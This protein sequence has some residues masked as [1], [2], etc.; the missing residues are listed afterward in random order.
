M[1]LLVSTIR[2]ASNSTIRF[3]CNNQAFLRPN[4]CPVF[5]ENTILT[6]HDYNN[7]ENLGN[8]ER[9]DQSQKDISYTLPPTVYCNLIKTLKTKCFET[10][11]LEIWKYHEKT[12]E[13]LT[14]DDV[15]N[16]VHVLKRRCYPVVKVAERDNFSNFSMFPVRTLASG[17]NT[18]AKWA[19]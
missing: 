15:I 19:R 14:D 9:F 6:G 5:I 12:I 7:F 16:A 1:T 17:P 11:I 3:R 10:S 18:P 4:V 8:T 2:K 13:K